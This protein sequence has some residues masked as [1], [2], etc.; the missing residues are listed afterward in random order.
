MQRHNCLCYVTITSE[1]KVCLVNS[2]QLS[3]KVLGTSPALDDLRAKINYIRAHI[4]IQ[5]IP[6]HCNIPG[7]DLADLAAKSATTIQGE[8]PGISYASICTLIKEKTK[9]PL[10]PTL[11][12]N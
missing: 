6:G 10:F 1:S 2:K 12:Y 7:N 5:W 3:I 11:Y 9:D 8:N 4:V